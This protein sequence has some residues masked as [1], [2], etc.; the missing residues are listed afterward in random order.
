M[1]LR[2]FALAASAAC[3]SMFTHAGSL[4]TLPN[5]ASPLAVV[6]DAK[7]GQVLFSKNANNAV[8]MASM[9]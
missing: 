3:F 1:S 4:K 5:L 9:T 6:Q 2:L 8:S 7:T